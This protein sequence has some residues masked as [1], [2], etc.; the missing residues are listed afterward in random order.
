MTPETCK[1]L[2]EDRVKMAKLI[3]RTCAEGDAPSTCDMGVYHTIGVWDKR[4]FRCPAE[5]IHEAI[6]CLPLL[7]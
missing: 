4:T 1:I 7:K 2:V 3:C 6:L 5:K